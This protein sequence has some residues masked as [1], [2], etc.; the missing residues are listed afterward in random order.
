MLPETRIFD[1]CLTPISTDGNK[2][3][4]IYLFSGLLNLLYFIWFLLCV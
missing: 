1:D 4:F 3:F 2:K